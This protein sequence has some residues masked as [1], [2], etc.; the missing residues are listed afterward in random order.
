MPK[1]YSYIRFSCLKEFDPNKMKYQLDEAKEFARSR[2]LI[3]DDT[4]SFQDLGVS[5]FKGFNKK[6][7][8]LGLFLFAVKYGI[9]PK[10]S[11]LI[12]ENLD[13]LSRDGA[14]HALRTLEEIVDFGITVVTLTDRKEYTAETLDNN[15][16][17]L[18]Y[19]ILIFIRANEESL[20]KSRRVR[21]VWKRKIKAARRGEKSKMM[22]GFPRWL[23][24]VDGKFVINEERGKIIK[25]IFNMSK[26]GM[27]SPSIATYFNE[28][29]IPTLTGLPIWHGGT[30][31]YYLRNSSVTGRYIP[32]TRRFKDGIT[33]VETL[34]AVDDFYPRVISERTWNLVQK[35]IDRRR[36]RSPAFCNG[37]SNQ[38]RNIFG[39][40]GRCEICGG[41]MI[42]KVKNIMIVP[43]KINHAYL[44]CAPR[45]QKI[46]CSYQ[47]I[48]YHPLHQTFLKKGA[49]MIDDHLACLLEKE[50]PEGTGSKN[51]ERALLIPKVDNLKFLLSQTD[52][53]RGD[54][55]KALKNLFSSVVF[56]IEKGR[57]E[58]HWAYG[59]VSE[60]SF[61]KENNDF[62]KDLIRNL[63]ISPTN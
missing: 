49:E 54:L 17:D 61:L 24:Y 46:K 2:N 19:S 39:R 29:S 18:L 10:G 42:L 11:Y 41:P 62:I 45:H 56:N 7:G 15:P 44:S 37:T 32:K 50:K 20:T 25:K 35:E 34:P 47:P 8:K 6:A 12:I 51:L 60:L 27:G 5:G 22:G 36:N 43:Y 59:G 38:V 23:D 26:V 28:L 30:V 16:M 31:L 58:F 14:R 4:L 3:F 40:L 52:P 13:R 21:A 1:A 33:T 53:D 55:N 9:V 48:L 57:L 63:E